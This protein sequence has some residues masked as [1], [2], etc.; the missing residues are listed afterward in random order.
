M[1][2]SVSPPTS[3]AVADLEAELVELL[4]ARNVSTEPR[5]RER[6]SV[7]G[8]RMSPII[9]EL[10][11]LGLADLVAF[12]TSAE[13]IGQAVAAAVRHGV[14]VTPRGKGTGNYGQG[15]PM[16]GGLVLDLSRAR[17]VVEVGD[18]FVTAEA[19]T[20]MVTLERAAHAT[21]QQLWMYPSTAQSSV[22]GFL[23]GGSG[24]TGSIVHGTNDAGFVAALDVVHGT[25]S[26]ELVHVEGDEAQ[27]FVHNYGT[28]GVIARATVRLEPLQDWRGLYASFPDFRS[29]QAVLRDLA[30]LE[31]RPRLVSADTPEI[32]A[33]LPADPALPEGRAS[34]RVIADERTVRRATEIVEAGGGRVE[35]VREGAQTALTLSMLS[36]NHPIEWLQKSAPGVYFHLEVSGAALIDRID[37]VHAVYEGGMLHQEI[38]HSGPIGMLAGVYRSPEQVLDGIRALN[39]L[40]VGV[41]NPHQWNVDFQL[42]RTVETARRTDPQGLLNPGKLNPDYAGPTKGAVS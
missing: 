37:E 38:G 40:G 34:V 28:A 20:P 24:G 2:L 9:S 42:A 30:A 8:A 11:P 31:P 14:P 27:L 10:L 15:I 35:D 5:A 29:A 12:P 32:T 16:A 4:G 17:A 22:G 1:T 18:G 25:G 41:H 7:D 39:E 19:G 13:Q 3:S 36:Y 6:A 33:T 21:G 26:P 23:A